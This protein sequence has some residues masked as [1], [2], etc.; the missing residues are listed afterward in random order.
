[1][2]AVVD[3]QLSNIGSVLNML[4]YL[5]VEANITTNP[6]EVELSEKII[7]PGVGSFDRAMNNIHELGLLSALNSRVLEAKVPVLG[8]CLGMQ[9]LGEGSEEGGIEGLSWIKGSC[10]RFDFSEQVVGKAEDKLRIP[11]MGWNTVFQ[12]KESKLLQDMYDKPRFYFVHSYY[13]EVGEASDTLLSTKH[14]EYFTSAVERE[15]IYGTQFHPEKS[16]KFGS[17]LI[18]NFV[19][20][21]N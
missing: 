10:K 8:I 11:H 16:H 21:C 13:F 3:F 18:S 20:N 15:N 5:G 14:G 9:I 19:N 12:K 4:R 6:K 7:L 2:I 17:Q 1:M